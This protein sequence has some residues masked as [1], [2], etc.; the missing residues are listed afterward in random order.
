MIDPAIFNSGANTGAMSGNEVEAL[1]K[2]LTAGYGTDMTQLNGGAALRVQSLDPVMQTTLQTESSFTL[3]RRI[4]KSKP[5]GTVDEWTEQNS[6]GGFLGGSTNS[7]VGVINQ[8]TGNYQRMVGMVKFLMT[9]RQVS[10]VVTLQNA[11]ADAEA[12][13]Y[14]N[15]SLQ[16][17]SDANYLLYEGDD[18]AVP[19][20]FAGIKA[21]LLAGVATGAVDTSNIIDMDGQPLKSM[22]P[23]NAASAQVRRYGNFGRSTD[24]FFNQDVQQ[25]FDNNLDPAF[26]VALN[27]QGGAEGGLKLGAPVVG[28][29]TSGGPV[30]TNEDVFIRNADMKRPFQLLQPVYAAASAG[31][32]PQ[33][34]TNDSAANT[35]AQSKFS[36]SRAGT[37]V[38]GVAGT[39]NNGTSAVVLTGQIAVAASKQVGLT[40]TGS[41][42]GQETGYVIYRGRQNGPVDVNDLREVA[43]IPRTGSTTTF[44]DQNTSIPG[45][46][47]AYILN[48]TP[49]ATA[50]TFRQLLPM[51]KWQLYPTDSPIIPWAQM[52]FGFLRISKRKHHV[53]VKNI[54]PVN[55]FWRPFTAE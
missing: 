14:H 2:A 30:A 4:A 28:I 12:T 7:E 47:E 3:F 21:Q 25:D 53:L 26:R 32:T 15:G 45:S 44:I 24:I 36:A 6:I 1:Q 10:L 51:L 18:A 16:L 19:T 48:M 11:I 22:E 27:G 43:R 35:S 55:Q 9:R 31:L 8:A 29:R 13:E 5:G 17:C 39:N 42:A 52:L 40:I 34:V 54:V 20:E 50:I 41:L 38:Y 49:G 33:S 23:I 46:T 37:Y